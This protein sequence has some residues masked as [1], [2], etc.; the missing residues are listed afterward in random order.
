MESFAD[1]APWPP[2]SERGGR[3]PDVT[4]LMSVHNGMPYLPEAVNSILS[5][6]L[7]DFAFLIINDGSTDTTA[8][9]LH[10]L[11]D[12]RIWVLEGPHRGLGAALN[13]GLSK[14]TTEFLARMDADDVALPTRLEAQLRY[15]RRHKEVGLVG[16]RV[17]Y[18]YI[19]RRRGF[20]PP[21]PLEHDAI[22]QGY[23]SGWGGLFHPT[24]MCRTDILKSVGGY[25]VAGVG[26][27]LDVFL[28][29]GEVS[30]LAN[31]DEVLQL[32]RLRPESITATKLGEVSAQFAY[33]RN[34]A[35]RRAEHRPE[36]PFDEFLIEHRSRPLWHRAGEAMQHY[37]LSQYR[38]AVADILSSHPIR[39]YARLSWAAACSPQ[40]SIRRISREVRTYFGNAKGLSRPRASVDAS[41]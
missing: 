8:D 9:Y 14:C 12:Q 36:I 25:R 11:H 17:A 38:R 4:V 23:L 27:E 13:I 28:R 40:R 41:R 18:S 16:T 37:A 29:M 2:T 6:T 34:C 19:G 26:Q 1:A 35:T 33:A 32:W 5:Q 3:L 22:Y 39:G 30:K 10:E 7:Q 15:L 24:I 31:L 20:S 21:V